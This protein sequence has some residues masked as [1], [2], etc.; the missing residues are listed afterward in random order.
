MK[1]R[2]IVSNISFNV[3][4]E[5]RVRKCIAKTKFFVEGFDNSYNICEKYSTQLAYKSKELDTPRL[6]WEDSTSQI[7]ELG[8]FGGMPI[9]FEIIWKIIGGTYVAFWEPTSQVVHY[10]MIEDKLKEL[11]PTAKKSD[12]VNFGNVILEIIEMNKQIGKE[13]A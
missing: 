9:S 8:E 1:L 7:I 3:W 6:F 5:Y 13:I 12:Y 4:D 11:F 10:P 2:T